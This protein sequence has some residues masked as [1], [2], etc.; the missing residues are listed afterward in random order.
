MQKTII[1]SYMFTL[2][3]LIVGTPRPVTCT[4]IISLLMDNES[5]LIRPQCTNE[6]IFY[7]SLNRGHDIM[8][9]CRRPHI[10]L[11]EYGEV[12]TMIANVIEKIIID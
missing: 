1:I 6:N 12:Y 10:V 4:Y 7:T 8:I 5:Q 2:I 9:S 3:C 11:D